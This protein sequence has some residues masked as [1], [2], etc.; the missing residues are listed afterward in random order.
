M[1]FLR[2]TSKKLSK[3]GRNRKKKQVWRRPSGRD[4]KMREKRRGYP[5]TVS[6]GYKTDKKE[7]GLIRGLEPILV[8]NIKDLEKIKSKQIALIGK[9]GNKNRIKILEKAKELKIE[10][11][12]FNARKILKKITKKQESKEKISKENK[13]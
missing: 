13:K 10:I 3:L 8:K 2:R 5:L 11:S 12:N 6:I 9:I 1:K 7:R 4:N